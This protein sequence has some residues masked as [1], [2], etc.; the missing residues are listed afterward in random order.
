[1]GVSGMQ[2]LFVLRNT[3]L[4]LGVYYFGA[5][6]EGTNPTL[7]GRRINGVRKIRQ[8]GT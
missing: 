5:M 8:N 7:S 2:C 1:M 3:S 6:A 4:T